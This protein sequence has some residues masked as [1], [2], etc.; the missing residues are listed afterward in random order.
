MKP[1]SDELHRCSE[2]KTVFE[3]DVADADQNGPPVPAR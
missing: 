1:S 2:C 3:A